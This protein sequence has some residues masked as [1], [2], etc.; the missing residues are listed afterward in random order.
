MKTALYIIFLFLILIGFGC[1]RVFKSLDPDF[2]WRLKTGELILERGVP[3]TDWYSFTMPDFP[4]IDHAWLT[5]VLIYKIYSNFGFQ[6]LL[7]VFLVISVL[8]FVILIKPKQ[9]LFYSLPAV[10]GFLAILGFLGI[11]AQIITIFFIALLWKVLSQFL[12][13]QD[14]FSRSIFYIPI[15]FLIWANLHGGFFAGLFILFLF[16]ILEIFKKTFFFKKL[17]ALPFFQGQNFKEQSLKKTLTIFIVLF[18]SFLAT[19]VNP[20]GLRIYEEIL[21]TSSDNFLRLYIAEW[22]PLLFSNPSI[23]VI[24]YLALFLG[25]L[26]PLRKKIEFSQ[27]VIGLIFLVLA[28]LNQR[29]FPLFVVLSLPI[30][31]EFLFHFRQ[32]VIPERL[33]ILLAGFKKWLIVFIFLAILVYG[34]YPTV[35]Y[36]FK[37]NTADYY[38]ERALSFLKTLPLSDNLFNEYS[39]G[40]Y[41]IWKIPERKLFID[42][43]MPSWRQNN[44]FVFG[45]YVKI[46]K[47]EEGFEKLLDKYEVKIALLKNEKKKDFKKEENKFA[48]FLKKQTRLLK[49]LGLESQKKDLVKELINLNWQVIYEDQTAIILRK[50]ND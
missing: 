36:I 32:K 34:F 45:D 29:H 40:G 13:N 37:K 3:K 17:I 15:L 50:E 33:K 27:L 46:I 2:G 28:F 24:L 43:R 19:L 14:S 47:A 26:I 10:L 12:E 22:L 42:G 38:P 7:L 39:W 9:F 35:N 1:F 8:S 5:D 23:F 30:F 41:L 31:A 4:W 25:L 44:Q 21:R 11:R 48:N 49:I 16:L 18:F 20:Y 6:I